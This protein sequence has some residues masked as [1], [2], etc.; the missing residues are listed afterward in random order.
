MLG[1]KVKMPVNGAA[2][3][4][5]KVKTDL[6]PFLDVSRIDFFRAIYTDLGFVE[7]YARVHDRAGSSLAGSAVAKIHDRR[8]PGDCCAK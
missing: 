4:G 6:S 1:P 3:R 2:A 7:V 8:F 5:T